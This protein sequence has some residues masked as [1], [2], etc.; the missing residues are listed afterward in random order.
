M[1][2]STWIVIIFILTFILSFIFSGISNFI[3]NNENLN[4]LFLLGILILVVGTGIIFDMVGVASLTSNE[5]TFHAKATKKIKGAKSSI[6]IIKN[7]S[8]M[9]TVCCDIVGDICGIVSGSLVA[10][11][12]IYIAKHINNI[13]LV[14]TVITA[15][16]SALTVGT[17]AIL[18]NVAVKKCDN[19]IEIVGKILSIVNF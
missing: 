13:N 3:A 9:A 14:T 8:K 1:K 4:V 11:L 12:A 19:I 7:S 6:K 17:K 2:K 10:I 5:A 16:V 15:I 18:K